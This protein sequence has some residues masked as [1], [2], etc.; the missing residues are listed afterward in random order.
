[1]A[2]TQNI[3]PH[4]VSFSPKPLRVTAWP[5]LKT[6]ALIVLVFHAVTKTSESNSVASTQNISPHCVSFSP[7]TSESNSVATPQNIS[8]HCVS[9]S[10]K[11]LRVT[12]W[13]ALKT[14]ALIVL[15]FHQ[16]L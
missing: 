13:P 5:A 15:V 2:S 8:P 16:N 3:S 11:P 9:F 14:L 1:M 6:L 10:P 7:K 12:A 4:C